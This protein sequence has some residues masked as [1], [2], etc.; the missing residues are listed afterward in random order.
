MPNQALQQTPPQ[1]VLWDGCAQPCGVAAELV[2]RRRRPPDGARQIEVQPLEV[3]ATDSNYA[4]VK[5]PGR[6][7]PGTVVQGDSLRHLAGLAAGVAHWFRDC[8]PTDDPD[9]LG[10]V[11]ELA[12]LLVDRL[13]HYQRVLHAHGI[14]LPYS[15]PLTEADIVRLLPNAPDAEPD[16]A[17]DRRGV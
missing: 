11:Q 8:G 4:V 17:A 15:Q 16:A 6:Q 1:W 13:V 10:D 7:F 9:V 5:P 3:Y 14:G 2:V 12:E